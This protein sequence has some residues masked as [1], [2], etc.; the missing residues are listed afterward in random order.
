MP[1]GRHKTS[2]RKSGWG[3]RS[4]FLCADGAGQWRCTSARPCLASAVWGHWTECRGPNCVPHREPG[5]DQRLLSWNKHL[6]TRKKH[7]QVLFTGLLPF[8]KQNLCQECICDWSSSHASVPISS[9][10]SQ[11]HFNTTPKMLWTLLHSQLFSSLFIFRNFLRLL[12][13]I[14]VVLYWI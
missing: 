9:K 5:C 3:G 11:K 7:K 10:H 2:R 1:R 6:D 13:T 4:C 8:P 14:S 12:T